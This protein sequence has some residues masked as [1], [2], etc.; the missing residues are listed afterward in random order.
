VVLDDPPKRYHRR[1]GPAC[2]RP[3]RLRSAVGT[4]DAI[5]IGDTPP[6]CDVQGCGQPAAPHATYWI[7]G[8]PWIHLCH[9]HW[10]MTGER[11]AELRRLLGIEPRPPESG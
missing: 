8:L 9:E 7:P 4:A 3:P 11:R 1:G 10:G 2:S 5:G 6:I